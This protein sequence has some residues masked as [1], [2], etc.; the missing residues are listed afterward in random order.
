MRKT[1]LFAVI[2][3][4]G[5]VVPAIGA[6]ARTPRCLGKR[7]TIVGTN[8][9][10]TIRGTA[11]ADVIVALGGADTINARGG[12]D[13]ICG[14]RGNDRILG[15]AGNTDYLFGQGGDD[16]LFGAG[17]F[18][19]LS[20]GPGDD[21]L[22]GGPHP[23]D[24]VTFYFAPVGVTV[25]LAS[26]VATGEG[27]DTL[28]AVEYV[29]GS[30][31]NDTLTGDD[32]PNFL[33]GVA[34]DDVIDGGG[35]SDWTYLWT[36]PGPV[37]VDL[38]AGT[39]TGDGTDSLVGVENVLGSYFADSITGDSSDNVIE[40]ERGNDVINGMDGDDVLFGQ[41]GDDSLDGGNGTDELIGGRGTDAC[42]N[43]EV[44]DTCEA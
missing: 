21:L 44:V 2:A 15:G 25:D 34:G 18:D 36:A 4:A 40:G 5:I 14:G 8:R 32:Q 9:G 28:Q 24:F 17:G 33:Q 11:G 6:D 35:G 13:R 7:A 22:N 39:S 3:L 27:T 1:T 41:A 12:N 19:F 38:S 16:Q 23:A 10:E 31:H 43:G 30:Q 20:G 26:G 29:E 42:T 37:T